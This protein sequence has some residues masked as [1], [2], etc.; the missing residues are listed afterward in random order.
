MRGPVKKQATMGSATN[1]EGA[2][3]GVL[4][5]WETISM[6]EQ[7]VKGRCPVSSSKAMTP[8]AYRSVRGPTSLWRAC[9]GAMY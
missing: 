3:G 6:W 4:R 8:T 5:W 7:P 1:K 2:S 9:S